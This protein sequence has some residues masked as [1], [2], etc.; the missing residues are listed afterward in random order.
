M[1]AMETKIVPLSDEARESIPPLPVTPPPPTPEE[2]A[3]QKAYRRTLYYGIRPGTRGYFTPDVFLE[4]AKPA[5]F[6]FEYLTASEQQEF[7]EKFT[8]GLGQ[9][10]REKL[11]EAARWMLDRKLLSWDDFTTAKGVQIPFEVLDERSKGVARKLTEA[12]W[13][14]IPIPLRIDLT[15]HILNANEADEMETQGVK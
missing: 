12:T 11:P 8:Q 1:D 4:D 9:I 13:D 10:V 15:S 2:L 3:A 7:S 14:S 5:R 6:H